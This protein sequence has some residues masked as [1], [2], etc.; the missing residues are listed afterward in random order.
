MEKTIEERLKISES[1]AELR[2]AVWKENSCIEAGVELTGCDQC[3]IEAFAM[4]L[5]N[6]KVLL[7][8]VM[9]SLVRCSQIGNEEMQGRMIASF[10]NGKTVNP[11]DN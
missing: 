3:L 9:R 4:S 11:R 6:D 10:R 7:G 8:V 5:K 2:I 1:H